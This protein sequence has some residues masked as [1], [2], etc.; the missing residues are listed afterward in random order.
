[1]KKK[2]DAW[3]GK[4]EWMSKKDRQIEVEGG[5]LVWEL[6]ARPCLEHAAEVL[7]PGGKTTNRNLE[8]VQE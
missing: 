4:T 5:R 2:A 7:W 8:A 6:L 3:A 1:M